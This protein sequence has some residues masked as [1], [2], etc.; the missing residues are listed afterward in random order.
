[1][2]T[3]E[4]GEKHAASASLIPV[5]IARAADVAAIAAAAGVVAIHHKICI[6]HD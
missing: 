2:V 4:C 5:A 6:P 1:M 3:I